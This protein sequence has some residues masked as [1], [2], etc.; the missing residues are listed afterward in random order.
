MEHHL[1]LCSAPPDLLV[2]RRR[3]DEREVVV[4]HPLLLRDTRLCRLLIATLSL[5]MESGSNRP[6]D[7]IV[8]NL[9]TESGRSGTVELLLPV[10]GG[11]NS[12][13]FNPKHEI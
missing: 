8:Q 12:A 2:R 6:R 5:A 1:L 3:P 10:P 13:R 11:S 4:S 9:T 7:S